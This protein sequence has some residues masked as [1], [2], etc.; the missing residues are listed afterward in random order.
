MKYCTKEC[1][2]CGFPCR[3]EACPNYEVIHYVCEKCG[4]EDVTLYH[5]YDGEICAECLL[6]EFEIVEGSDM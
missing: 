1:C 2:D 4:A 5:Y 3:H 6:K